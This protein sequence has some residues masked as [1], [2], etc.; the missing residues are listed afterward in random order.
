MP[1]ESLQGPP[2]FE[3]ALWA[4]KYA[5]TQVRLVLKALNRLAGTLGSVMRD[6]PA[7]KEIELYIL[8]SSGQTPEELLDMINQ[9][10]TD[11]WLKEDMMSTAEMLIARGEARGEAR[12]RAEGKTEEKLDIARR[13]KKSGMPVAQICQ[14][15][16]L[17]ETDIASL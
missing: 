6:N 14:A 3:A 12:G 17:D 15:T 10:L 1:D 8:S 2:Q 11:T 13:L 5:R 7:F 16:G 9:L 4:M